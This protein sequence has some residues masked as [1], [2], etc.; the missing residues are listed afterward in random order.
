MNANLDM[1]VHL[2]SGAIN[3]TFEHTD[4]GIKPKVRSSVGFKVHRQDLIAGSASGG[5]QGAPFLGEH[6]GRLILGTYDPSDAGQ[7]Y[8]IASP[9]RVVG[10]TAFSL[11]G[12]TMNKMSPSP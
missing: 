4:A 3:Y 5:G 1:S 2:S 11:K 7:V 10:P 12:V 9:A 6:H 8:A